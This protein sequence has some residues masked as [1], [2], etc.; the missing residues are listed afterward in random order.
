M[1]SVKP[2][3]DRG[4]YTNDLSAATRQAANMLLLRPLVWKVVK[5]SVHG[6]DNLD[7][8]DGAYV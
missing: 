7:G 8:L 3:K 1:A 5:V 2:T 4:R 6:A